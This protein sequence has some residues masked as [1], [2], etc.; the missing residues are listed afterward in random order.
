MRRPVQ[1][2]LIAVVVLLAAATSV[3]YVRYRDRSAQ[4]VDVKAKEE[5]AEARYAETIDAIAEIQDSLS[6][7]SVDDGSKLKSQGLREEQNLTG[8]RSQQTLEG[9]AQIRASISRNRQRIQQLETSLK[10]RGMESA[11][12]RKLIA[13]LKED[14][15]DK[16]LMVANLN[17]RVE[18]LQT[19]VAGLNTE[20]RERDDTLR[21]RE[22]DLEQR[23]RELA[24]VYYVVGDKKQLKESGVVVSKGGVLGVGETVTPSGAIDPSVL[25]PLD[26]DAV[27]YVRTSAKKAK[28]VSAQPHSSYEMIMRD[29]EVVVHILDPVEFRKVKHL[30]ILRN[31]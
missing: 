25:V 1:I 27:D 18:T 4:Y 3:L 26:T 19:E 28:V 31:T 16:E 7:I 12:L 15:A 11:G 5:A 14:V 10:K 30:V 6:A 9:I 22:Q 8:P 2:A 13:R 17:R 21:E 20:V 24:T 29:G 23:R